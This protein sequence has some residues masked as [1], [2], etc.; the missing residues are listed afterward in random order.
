MTPSP[1]SLAKAS[2]RAGDAR[3]PRVERL[4]GQQHALARRQGKC[5]HASSIRRRPEPGPDRLRRHPARPA[6]AVD[7][8][9]AGHGTATTVRPAGCA[10]AGRAGGG[11]LTMTG[12]KHA[13]V[14][15]PA[16]IVVPVAPTMAAAGPPLTARVLDM[17]AAYRCWCEGV[18]LSGDTALLGRAGGTRLPRA[19]ACTPKPA[20]RPLIPATGP[21]PRRR[22]AGDPRRKANQKWSKHFINS[23]VRRLVQTLQ[24]GVFGR[25]LHHGQSRWNPVW[26]L[27]EGR[28]GLVFGPAEPFI[29]LPPARRHKRSKR[30]RTPSFCYILNPGFEKNLAAN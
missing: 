5:P 29:V 2:M 23:R 21:A 10:P 15:S 28:F 12:Q 19:V 24:A 27:L 16:A 13:L 1:R 4:E 14:R 7:R 25:F 8:S 20:L 9:P 30:A 17:H 22:L 6:C 11:G 26:R 3:S 18:A